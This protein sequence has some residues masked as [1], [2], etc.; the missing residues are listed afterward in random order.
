MM[1]QNQNASFPALHQTTFDS[2]ALGGYSRAAELED[3]HMATPIALIH[4]E[5]YL[6]YGMITKH[7]SAVVYTSNN[8]HKAC[9]L[10]QLILY[11]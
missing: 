2:H 3:E 10:H 9:Q 4:K 5:L 11:S 8:L 6:S 7:V 1:S